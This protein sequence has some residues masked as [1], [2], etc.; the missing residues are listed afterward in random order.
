MT[1][2]DVFYQG[3]GIGEIAYG[4]DTI[5]P[6]VV[7]ST[8][9]GRS[10]TGGLGIALVKTL[11]GLHGGRVETDIGTGYRRVTCVIP[12]NANAAGVAAD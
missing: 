3:E 11:I 9:V 4:G 8:S 10:A 12:L 7:D 6:S 2:I 1:S 5:L